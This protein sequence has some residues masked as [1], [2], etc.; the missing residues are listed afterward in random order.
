MKKSMDVN[1]IHIDDVL[2]FD[3]ETAPNEKYFNNAPAVLRE[4]LIKRAVKPNELEEANAMSDNDL[5]IKYGGLYPEISK[6]VCF[7]FGRFKDGILYVKSFVDLDEVNI[8]KR[9]DDLLSSPKCFNTTL[10]G[11]NIVDFDI[12][13]IGKRF[14]LSKLTIPHDIDYRNKQVWDYNVFDT[15]RLWSFGSQNGHIS[16]KVIAEL[17]D[18]PTPKDDIDGSQ[19]AFVYHN[20]KDIKRIS[21]YCQKDVICTARVFQS[22]RGESWVKDENV[23]RI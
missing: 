11:H 8:L 3:V 2:F 13:F 5:F 12:P 7:S 16:L 19:V 1:G 21:E 20:D 6:I 15:K 22:L 4:F 10:C 17:F 23:H 9:I 14:L 18:I